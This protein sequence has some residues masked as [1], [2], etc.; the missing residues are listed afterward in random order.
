MLLLCLFKFIIPCFQ[1]VKSLPNS[2]F[3]I[4]SS[5]VIQRFL[6]SE[7]LTQIAIILL[8]SYAGNFRKSNL[9]MFSCKY[10]PLDNVTIQHNNLLETIG[11][12]LM[13]ILTYQRTQQMAKLPQNSLQEYCT[14]NC[15]DGRRR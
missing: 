2:V 5:F 7:N 12:S 11:L 8:I 13:K 4:N 15:L 14:G 1:C 9:N 6:I 3:L 10:V